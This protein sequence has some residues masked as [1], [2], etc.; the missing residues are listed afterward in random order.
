MRTEAP[1]L[2]TLYKA[3]L[4]VK[5]IIAGLAVLAIG[6]YFWLRLVVKPKRLTQSGEA[7]LILGF[8]AGLMVTEFTFGASHFREQN[9]T[10]SPYE[11]VTSGVLWAP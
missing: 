3:Y 4:F 8:I 7:L 9:I 11:P 2:A 6:Y 10:W 1:A 5:D